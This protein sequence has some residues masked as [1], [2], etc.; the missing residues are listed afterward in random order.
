M[1]ELR[2]SELSQIFPQL[3]PFYTHAKYLRELCCEVVQKA[4]FLNTC[5]IRD[6]SHNNRLFLAALSH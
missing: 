2:A 3:G 4:I 6:F 5:Q 1:W